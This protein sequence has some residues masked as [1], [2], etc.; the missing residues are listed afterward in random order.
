MDG[1]KRVILTKGK[2]IAGKG[3]EVPTR[4][5]SAPEAPADSKEGRPTGTSALCLPQP[6]LSRDEAQ[7]APSFP[8]S[9]PLSIHLSFSMSPHPF[10]SPSLHP[11]IHPSTPPSFP[12]SVP[13]PI[14][15]SIHPTILL[16][17][18]PSILPSN[19]PSLHPALLPSLPPCIPSFIHPSIPPSILPPL[20]GSIHPSLF[21][22]TPP[23]FCPPPR[24]SSRDAAAARQ[25][26]YLARPRWP[27]SLTRGTC[28]PGAIAARAAIANPRPPGRTS[29]EIGRRRAST[30][31][32]VPRDIAPSGRRQR[33]DSAWYPDPGGF[34]EMESKDCTL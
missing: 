19:P 32:R 26:P 17:L 4:H 8:P 13:P 15:P 16:S 3:L 1:F 5:R 10:L 33:S 2:M 28:S 34:W 12:P 24:H 25:E 14:H 7:T 21:P 9:L 20:Q 30:G 6:S 18:H 11:F 23:S 31:Q 27:R 29:S 22:S